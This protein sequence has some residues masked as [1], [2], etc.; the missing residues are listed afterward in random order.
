MLLAP[1]GPRAP[2]RKPRSTHSARVG[3][4][5]SGSA[6]HAVAT[7]RRRA[8]ARRSGPWA[9]ASGGECSLSCLASSD[10]HHLSCLATWPACT[11]SARPASSI[12]TRQGVGIARSP[13]TLTFSRPGTTRP[14]ARASPQ[15]PALPGSRVFDGTTARASLATHRR[16]SSSHQLS[17][18]ALA[19]GR[20]GVLLALL[21]EV[22]P[23][24][25]LPPAARGDRGPMAWTASR[26]RS[27]ATECAKGQQK[28][29]Q[30]LPPWH[31]R[32]LYIIGW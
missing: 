3:A 1:R 25:V 31:K 7:V 28:S 5:A 19:A 10:I 32:V 6:K 24:P 14:P 21:P 20:V 2:P 8:S 22:W 18:V 15:S 29:S 30:A 9:R 27:S 11:R 12:F 13:L 17:P 4:A 23:A 26:S 16:S